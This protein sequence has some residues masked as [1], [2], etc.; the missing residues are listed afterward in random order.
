VDTIGIGE[1][2]ERKGEPHATQRSYFARLCS[3]DR[4]IRHAR[5]PTYERG[6]RGAGTALRYLIRRQEQITYAAFRVQGYPIG[7]GMVESAGKL[8]IEARLKGSWVPSG[9]RWASK[10]VNPLLALRGP[11]CS[12][13]WERIW[14]VIWQAWRD[15]LRLP[16]P[17][18]PDGVGGGRVVTG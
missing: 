5:L 8:E 2:E 6:T 13:Q 3:A 4:F 18:R 7:S 9:C 16:R 12:G 15:Q 14:P 11:S 1:V 10:N 17:E